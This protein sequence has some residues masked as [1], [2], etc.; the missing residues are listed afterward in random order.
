MGDSNIR[1]CYVKDVFEGKLKLETIFIQTNTKEALTIAVEKQT[2]SGKALIFHSSWMNEIVAKAKSKDEVSKD[3]EISKVVDDIIENLYRAAFEKPNWKIVLMKPIR[4]KTPASMDIRTFKIAELIQQSFY[5][6]QPPKNLKLTGAPSIEDKH[7]VADGVHL[8]RE[9]SLLLQG[10]LIEEITK[11]LQEQEIMEQDEVFD[12]D[13]DMGNNIASLAASKLPRST[14]I[15]ISQTPS[16]VNTRSKRTRDL[17]DSNENQETDQS[18]KKMRQSEDRME[19]IL[20]RMETLLEGAQTTNAENAEKIGA[21]KMSIDKNQQTTRLELDGINLTIARLKEDNDVLDNDRMRDT[22]IIKKIKV[23]NNLPTQPQELQDFIKE[24]GKNMI[25]AILP[26]QPEVKYIGLAYPIEVA[27]MAKAPKEV[28]PIKIHF[29]DREVALSFK[30][31]AIDLAKKPSGTY[32]GAY[33]VHPLNPATRIRIQIL[34][35]LVK[36]LKEAKFEAWVAQSTSRPMLMIK[37]GQYPKAFGFVQAITEHQNYIDKCDFTEATK[38]ANR[39]FKGD[40][41]RLF[42]VLSD[43]NHKGKKL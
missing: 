19:S 14:L 29:K 13:D 25:E 11:A 10:H 43:V 39:F 21:N 2:K 4:R 22:I 1:N 20:A 40:V 42:I 28:P 41:Q 15:S 6:E 24:F 27:R 30:A 35:Q 23:N 17:E 16:R 32:S 34:W 37:K 12:Q 3:N 31:K 26:N 38:L 36:I 9:G 7:F 8:T 18:G 5:K 33:L